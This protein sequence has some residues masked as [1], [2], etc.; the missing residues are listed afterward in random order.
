MSTDT[1]LFISD[2]LNDLINYSTVTDDKVL[3]IKNKLIDAFKTMLDIDLDIH[4]VKLHIE[5]CPQNTQLEL[6]ELGLCLYNNQKLEYKVDV[7]KDGYLID[8]IHCTIISKEEIELIVKNCQLKNFPQNLSDKLQISYVQYETP[9]LTNL[10]TNTI[11]DLQVIMTNGSIPSQ[12]CPLMDTSTKVIKIEHPDSHDK[13]ILMPELDK[14]TNIELDTND[15]SLYTVL[16]SRYGWGLNITVAIVDSNNHK[17]YYNQPYNFDYPQGLAVRHTIENGI[18]VYFENDYPIQNTLYQSVNLKKDLTFW[19]MHSSTGWKKIRIQRDLESLIKYIK[20]LTENPEYTNISTY[21]E[22]INKNA[23]KFHLDKNYNESIKLFEKCFNGNYEAN[24]AAYNVACGYSLLDDKTNALKWIDIAKNHG[25]GEGWNGSWYNA[26]SDPDL[27]NIIDEAEF[28]DI[29]RECYKESINKY[30]EYK[31]TTDNPLSIL[32]WT[33]NNIKEPTV[34]EENDND[35][36]QVIDNE[37]TNEQYEEEK[38][39]YNTK[40]N[41]YKYLEKLAN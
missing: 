21:F 6:T 32:E 17:I 11:N 28:Q 20:I 14:Y 12:Y 27:A 5:R 24:S 13:I 1:Q 25:F 41:F 30:I 31:K 33:I 4:Q 16:L 40:V 9:K 10:Q 18:E 38:K 15:N 8:I 3:N 34:S 39:V 29:I 37:E 36:Q 22:D 35:E 19:N 7:N 2:E 23:L 26:I